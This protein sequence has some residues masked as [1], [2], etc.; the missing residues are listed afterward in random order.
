MTAPALAS[1]DLAPRLRRERGRQ[2]RRLAQS[3]FR[4]YT[5]APMSQT[6]SIA[7]REGHAQVTQGRL[8]LAGGEISG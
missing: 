6:M 1:V 3:F 4:S 2:S 8:W 7:Q 5:S